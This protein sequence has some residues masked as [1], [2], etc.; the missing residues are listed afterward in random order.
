[1]R[2]R[3]TERAQFV[4]VAAED[5]AKNL[6]SSSVYP[7]HLLLATLRQGAEAPGPRELAQVGVDIQRL[8]VEVERR[9][10]VEGART[11]EPNWDL[12]AEE[13]IDASNEM[14]RSLSHKYVGT[15]HILLALLTTDEGPI[16]QA[17]DS[18][19]V[20]LHLVR[21]AVT[22]H[23]RGNRVSRSPMWIP[24]L[25]ADRVQQFLIAVWSVRPSTYLILTR[26]GLSVDGRTLTIRPVS[27]THEALLRRRADHA[28]IHDVG[29]AMKLH[30]VI[31]AAQ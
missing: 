10:T 22:D 25:P 2:G 6:G 8:I 29:E 14:A 26:C 27:S 11:A 19:G 20:D 1:M 9:I 17:F 15:E 13:I 5:E 4:T 18:L 24:P 12:S 16:R 31:V 3:W 23:I 21:T 30:V 28:V 7:E